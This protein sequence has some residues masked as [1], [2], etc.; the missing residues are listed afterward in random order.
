MNFKRI[1]LLMCSLISSI[2]L[3][4][5]SDLG[6]RNSKEIFLNISYLFKIP[7]NNE[8]WSQAILRFKSSLPQKGKADE[9]NLVSAAAFLNVVSIGCKIVMTRDLPLEPTA[10]LRPLQKVPTVVPALWTRDARQ[11]L[12]ENFA[13]L[14][15]ARPP[16]Q[17]E[18]DLILQALEKIE[19]SE[20][21]TE[22]TLNKMILSACT[23]TGASLD[24]WTL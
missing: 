9:I 5:Y 12:I 2:P 18:M 22:A 17:N 23:L 15:W 24:S 20:G 1:L 7:A 19:F 8:S 14:F 4:S 10:R 13:L 11:D 21:Q 3:T 6:V 16:K